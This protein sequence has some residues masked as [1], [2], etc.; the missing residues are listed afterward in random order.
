MGEGVRCRV[1]SHLLERLALCLMNTWGR[2]RW[3]EVVK[4]YVY[5]ENNNIIMDSINA[6]TS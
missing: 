5:D 6:I 2:R 3:W 1:E 4:S